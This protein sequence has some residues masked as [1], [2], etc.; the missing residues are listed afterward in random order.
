M[1]LPLHRFPSSRSLDIVHINCLPFNGFGLLGDE[2][3][4]FGNLSPTFEVVNRTGVSSQDPQDL[5]DL[6]FVD[7]LPRFDYRHK[8]L[9]APD[10]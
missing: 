9:C 8:A 5:T 1:R 6:K 2:F 4:V 10:I 3:Y 7:S